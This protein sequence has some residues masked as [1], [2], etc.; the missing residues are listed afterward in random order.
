LNRFLG[1]VD[2]VNF[3]DGEETKGFEKESQ[4]T[5]IGNGLRRWILTKGFD[6]DGY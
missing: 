4:M 1:W 5:Q 6:A 3:D 2:Q